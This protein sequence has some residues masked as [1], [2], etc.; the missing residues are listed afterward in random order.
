MTVLC[1]LHDRCDYLLWRVLGK[2]ADPG[3]P[4]RE[5]TI[6]VILDNIGD[7]LRGKECTYVDRI[8]GKEVVGQDDSRE[9][10]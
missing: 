8:L 2:S 5:T 9:I 10:P 1:P 4:S 7:C 3:M 6:G